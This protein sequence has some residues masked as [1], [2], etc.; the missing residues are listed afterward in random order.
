[1]AT[2]NELQALLTDDTLNKAENATAD[3]MSDIL[4]GEDTKANGYDDVPENHAARAKW[5]SENLGRVRSEAGK[6]LWPALVKNQKLT[7]GQIEAAS[8]GDFK[9]QMKLFIIEYTN[10]VGA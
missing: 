1:M 7:V 8:V 4:Q 5:A 9:T 10:V 6:L 2:Y 3:I